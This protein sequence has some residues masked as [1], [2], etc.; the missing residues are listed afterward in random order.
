MTRKPSKSLNTA[1]LAERLSQVEEVPK[2]RRVEGDACLRANEDMEQEVVKKETEIKRVHL[3][4]TK[5]CQ[6]FVTGYL[7]KEEE[8]IRETEKAKGEAENMWRAQGKYTA[9][10]NSLNCWLKHDKKE[11]KEEAA[12]YKQQ[13]RKLRPEADKRS[14]ETE[15]LKT[16]SRK[17]DNGL[18]ELQT[19]LAMVK[20]EAQVQNKL[21]LKCK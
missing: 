15:Q 17:K 6:A 19:K 21:L 2:R 3:E 20:L 10:V 13:L 18:K 1:E 14:H 7:M 8:L 4:L 5:A 9:E 11:Q 16:E 12:Q